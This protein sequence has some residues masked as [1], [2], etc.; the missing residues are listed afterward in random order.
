MRIG[1]VIEDDDGQRHFL[2]SYDLDEVNQLAEKG[3]TASGGFSSQFA[4]LDPIKA[5]RCAAACKPRRGFLACV[6]RCMATSE[7]CDGG[8]DNCSP[9]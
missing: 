4:A 6:A 9:L 7:V 2:E 1:L 5:A 3:L 8:V